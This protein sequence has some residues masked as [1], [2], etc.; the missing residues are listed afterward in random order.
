MLGPIGWGCRKSRAFSAPEV[1]GSP[2]CQFTCPWGR[3]KHRAALCYF[4]LPKARPQDLPRRPCVREPHAECQGHSRCGTPAKCH[5]CDWT[6]NASC[7]M[8]V[9]PVMDTVSISN[10]AVPASA[11]PGDICW[12]PSASLSST[13][14]QACPCLG[15]NGLPATAGQA[16]GLD[17]ARTC[18]PLGSPAWCS[19]LVGCVRSWLRVPRT[20]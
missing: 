6:N 11:G 1:V 7:L 16:R 4:L 14:P 10:E 13:D 2:L 18:L 19:G 5:R 12:T 8:T 15:T 17:S 20:S 3:D 9:N